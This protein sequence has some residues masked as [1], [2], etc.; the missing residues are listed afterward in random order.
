MKKAS[1]LRNIIM[2]ISKPLK[3][4][5]EI[6]LEYPPNVK[7]IL[8]KYGN[9]IIQSIIIKRTP[10]SGL[11]TG[12][13]S[14]FSLGEFGRRMKSFDELFH[15]FI[16]ISTT[17]GKKISLEKVERVNM[18]VN[19]PRRPNEEVKQVSNM[20]QNI[21]IMQLME[22]GRKRMGNQFFRYDS[23]INNC[24]HFILNVLQA[25][26]IGDQSDYEF[27]KQPT[28]QLFE[29]LP[30]L[31]GIAHTATDIGAIANKTLQG[32]NLINSDMNNESMFLKYLTSVPYYNVLDIKNPNDIKKYKHA[33]DTINII[34]QLK[35]NKINGNGLKK[36]II[37]DVQSIVFLKKNDWNIS[38]AKKWLKDRKFKGLIPDV[39]DNTIKFRQL[40]PQFFTEF[41]THRL[42][43]KGI[44]LV[45]G[46]K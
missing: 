27:I 19:P 17:T 13:L 24:Q 41:K 43:N 2:E 39:T 32:G 10:V 18:I 33:I 37:I 40:N 7:E 26:G 6:S 1:S 38:N 35:E 29:E 3:S 11:L 45:F 30:I 8:N 25:S 9:E 4:I 44:L 5:M 34:K 14:V 16:E 21:T 42:S 31:K 20:P 22:N 46:L 23:K 36:N 28:E 12:T 15:L